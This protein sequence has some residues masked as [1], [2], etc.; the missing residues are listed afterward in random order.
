MCIFH[1]Q[2][3][4][5][6]FSE[7]VTQQSVSAHKPGKAMYKCPRCERGY[8]H[9]RSLQQHLRFECGKDPQFLCPYCPKKMKLKGNLKQ[10]ILLV[11][12]SQISKS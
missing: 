6:A 3:S 11:H 2:M 4:Q 5:Y 7:D 9:K 8:V 12:E 10:H 1:L